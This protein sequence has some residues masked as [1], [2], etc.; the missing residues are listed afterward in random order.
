MILPLAADGDSSREAAAR[1]MNS[2]PSFLAPSASLQP[3]LGVWFNSVSQGCSS[4]RT[5]L[6]MRSEAM[7][8]K[9]TAFKPYDCSSCCS[10]Q[11]AHGLPFLAS[12]PWVWCFQSH[13]D[14]SWQ[15]YKNKEKHFLHVHTCVAYTLLL[16]LNPDLNNVVQGSGKAFE[17]PYLKIKICYSV[18]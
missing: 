4:C 7:T 10:F 18:F 8:I 14:N 11:S 16:W 1:L 9:P 17:S 3:G 6:S 5:L 2:V 13:R 15:Q 12:V